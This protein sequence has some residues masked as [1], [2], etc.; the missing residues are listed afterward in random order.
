MLVKTLAFTSVYFF[1]SSLFNGL[2]A[3]QIKNSAGYFSPACGCPTPPGISISNPDI[4]ARGQIRRH[5][6][7]QRKFDRADR[8][9]AV[10]LFSNKNPNQYAFSKSISNTCRRIRNNLTKLPALQ[11]RLSGRCELSSDA[12]IAIRFRNEEAP[13]AGRGARTNIDRVHRRPYDRAASIRGRQEQS[14]SWLWQGVSLLI[15][16]DD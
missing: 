3:I 4:P 16:D 8:V 12:V 11:G 15:H 14:D 13:S 2:R 10:L 7:N 9:A 5:R 1:E 6:D